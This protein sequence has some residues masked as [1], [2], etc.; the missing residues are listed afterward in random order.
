M[1]DFINNNNTNNNSNWDNID[2]RDRIIAFIILYPLRL[3]L[4]F[5]TVGVYITLIIYSLLNRTY[6]TGDFFYGKNSSDNLNLIYSVNALSGKIIPL[7]YLGVL[8]IILFV[9]KEKL[10]I[11]KDNPY[12]FLNLLKIPHMK[13]VLWFRYGFILLCAIITNMKDKIVIKCN[14]CCKIFKKGIVFNICD[15]YNF[16]P[17]EHEPC[18]LKLIEGDRKQYIKKGREEEIKLLNINENTDLLAMNI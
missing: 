8:N 18:C 14:S 1:N 5:L 3:F 12:L 13:Q 15:E 6:I 16:L 17:T 2:E 11:G 7:F 10:P 4:Y 9:K